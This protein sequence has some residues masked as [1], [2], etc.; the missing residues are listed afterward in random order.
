MSVS[1]SMLV[2]NIFHNWYKTSYILVQVL[3]ALHLQWG[4][5]VGSVK[6]EI[7]RADNFRTPPPHLI[8]FDSLRRQVCVQELHVPCVFLLLDAV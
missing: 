5:W 4:G 7:R 3:L 1:S 2:Q 6:N 8:P